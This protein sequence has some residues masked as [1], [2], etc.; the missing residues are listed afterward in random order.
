MV[1]TIQKSSAAPLPFAPMDIVP[2][3][4]YYIKSELEEKGKPEDEDK[5]FNHQTIVTREMCHC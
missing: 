5:K 4:A 3:V 2:K 1:I